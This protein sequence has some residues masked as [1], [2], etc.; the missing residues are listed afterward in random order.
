MNEEREREDAVGIH[1]KK[2]PIGQGKLQKNI[3]FT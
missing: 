2:K 3:L 1:S